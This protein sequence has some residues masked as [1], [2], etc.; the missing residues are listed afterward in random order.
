MYIIYISVR[1]ATC[2][3]SCRAALRCL[4]WLF[5]KFNFNLA[6]F[7]SFFFVCLAEALFQ[8]RWAIPGSLFPPFIIIIFLNN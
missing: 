3:R 5:F 8:S 1:I 2:L 7:F 4:E 6:I